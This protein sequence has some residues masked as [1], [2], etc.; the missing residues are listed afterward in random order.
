MKD[1]ELSLF[2]KV[3]EVVL[4]SGLMY[5]L[6]HPTPWVLTVIAQLSPSWVGSDL[7]IGSIFRDLK[8]MLYKIWTSLMVQWL[9]ISLPMQGI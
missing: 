5:D 8:K 7:E 3:G 6:A 1:L 4:K 9:R 2:W